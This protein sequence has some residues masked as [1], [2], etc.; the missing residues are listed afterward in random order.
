MVGSDRLVTVVCVLWWGAVAAGA[1]ALVV[2]CFAIGWFLGEIA[3]A[4][5]LGVH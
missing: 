3:A 2:W 4:A 1:G 5:T